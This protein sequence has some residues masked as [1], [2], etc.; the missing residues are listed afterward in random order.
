MLVNGWDE[1]EITLQLDEEIS[2]YEQEIDKAF[3]K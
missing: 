1:I 2:N 3:V